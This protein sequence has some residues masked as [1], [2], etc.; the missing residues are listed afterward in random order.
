MAIRDVFKI[1]RKTFLYPTGWLDFT[2]VRT[3]NKTIWDSIRNLFRVPAPDRVENF[4]EAMHRL[5]MS[6]ADVEQAIKNYTSFAW[7]F[8]ILG[9]IVLLYSFYLA[10]AHVTISGFILG[11][12]STALF[13]SQAFQYHFWAFQMREKR[14]GLTFKDWK[15]HMLGE[16]G[17]HS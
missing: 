9:I 5:D 16:K 10:F 13:L 11:L 4:D 2:A 12:V 8:F 17:T 1:N 6:E 3:L 7:M 14:L 15:Q